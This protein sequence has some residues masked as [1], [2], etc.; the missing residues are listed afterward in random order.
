MSAET[1][2]PSPTSDPPQ[3]HRE[4]KKVAAAT[5]IGTTVEWYDF[6]IYGAVAATVLGPL[7]FP[8]DSALA[9]QLA[10]LA[11]FTVGFVARPVG[12]MVAGHYGDRIG[13]K[14]MLVFSLLLMGIVTIAVGFLP[15]YATIGAAAPILLVALRLGQ[16]FAVGAE[17]GGA[18][19]MAVEHAPPSKRALYGSAP[20]LGAPAGAILANLVVLGTSLATGPAFPEWGWRVPFLLSAALVI[21]GLIV[22]WQVTESPLFVEAVKRAEE[23]NER[24]N[25]LTTV[26]RR[27]PMALLRGTCFT[28]ASTA[29]AYVI[30]VF[31]LSYGT[32]EPVGYSQNTMLAV[33]IGCSVFQVAAMFYAGRLAD[34]Y[35]RKRV[36]LGGG[37]LQALMALVF[38]PLFDSGNLALVLF[39]TLFASLA[40][41]AQYGPLPALLTEQFPTEVRYTGVSVS[42]MLGNILGGG[43][44]PLVGTALVASTGTSFSVG[45]YLAVLSLITLAA[46]ALARETSQDDLTKVSS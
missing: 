31:I 24:A 20:A 1:A 44:V 35:G 2:P 18:A 23:K 11:T 21:I 27:H 28:I 9:S 12:A 17:W 40:M 34:R 30:L 6:F 19:L 13:R 36:V 25:P 45:V 7:F 16:G 4:A 37:V 39:V 38:F 29:W 5:F 46:V 8:S 32:S 15:T 26:V 22:R 43:L 14:R 10:A 42:Y 41:S 33:I 3:Q